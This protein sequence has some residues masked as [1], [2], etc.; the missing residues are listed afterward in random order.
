MEHACLAVVFVVAG[1]H[2]HSN[3]STWEIKLLAV[4]SSYYYFVVHVQPNNRIM[5]KFSQQIQ[6][7]F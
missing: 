3:R 6:E 2:V 7:R 4:S 1:L 5:Y